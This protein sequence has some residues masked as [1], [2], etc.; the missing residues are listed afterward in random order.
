MLGS[1]PDIGAVGDPAI[2]SVLIWTGALMVIGLVA[3]LVRRFVR[4]GGSRRGSTV[5]HFA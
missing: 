1:F 5:G 4:M 2:P 3:P